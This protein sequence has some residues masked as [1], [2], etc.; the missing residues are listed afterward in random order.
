MGMAGKEAEHLLKHRFTAM[1][2]H[3]DKRS[4]RY[5]VHGPNRQ[6]FTAGKRGTP[7]VERC[8][9]AITTHIDKR[10]S[11]EYVVHDLIGQCIWQDK[12]AQ[13]L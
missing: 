12:E 11:H 8:C 5:I 10:L 2:I 4:E 13:N 3:T 6:M 7:L 1:K 9:T